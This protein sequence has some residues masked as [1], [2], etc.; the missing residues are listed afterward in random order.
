[1]LGPIAEFVKRHRHEVGKHAL[2]VGSGMLL[3]P[4]GKTPQ[5]IIEDTARRETGTEPPRVLEHGDRATTDA[6][7]A[8]QPDHEERCRL[9]SEALEDSRTSEGHIRLARMIKDGYF[10]IIFWASPDNLIEQA[11]EH[12]RLEPERDFNLLRVGL[13]AP[14]QIR[15]AI[16]EST[17][18]TVVKIGGDL[19]RGLLPLTQDEFSKALA[20]VATYFRDALRSLLV[21]AAYADRDSVMLHLAPTDGDRMYWVNRIVPV[22]NRERYDELRVE[23]PAAAKFHAYQPD[24][25]ALLQRR[26][27]PRNLICR[28][29]GTFDEF[30]G[31]LHHRLQRR[32][33][34]RTDGRKDLTVLPGGPYRYLDHFDTRHADLFYGRDAETE[35]LRRLTSENP[36]TILCGPDGIGKSSLLRAGVAASMVADEKEADERPKWIPVVVRCTGDPVEDTRVAVEAALNDRGWLGSEG[37][38]AEYFTDAMV[39]AVDAA[40]TGIAVY[41]DGFEHCIV[42]RG[43][44]TRRGFGR[45]MAECAER[46]GEKWRLCIAVREEFL[47]YLL[48]L[49]EFWP[50]I[51]A[52]VLR[53][54]RLNDSEAI[55]AILKP[56]PAFLCY[57]EIEAAERAVADLDDGGVLPAHLQ[58]VM[59]RLYEHRS[60]G[61]SSITLKMYEF[62]HGAEEM[63]SE[64]VEFPL[65]KLGQRDRR[66]AR[67]IMKRLVGSQRTTVP[68]TL[69][70]IA[71]ECALEREVV[72][73]VLA[74]LTDLRLVRGIGKEADRRY[75]LIHPYIAEEMGADL[76]ERLV[77][78]A[79]YGD[80]IARATDE[81]VHTRVLPPL[82]LLRRLRECR[83]DVCL[84][85][86]EMEAVLR[87]A[88]TEDVDLDYWLRRTTDIGPER[89]PILRRLLHDPDEQVRR[90]AADGLSQTAD[91]DALSTLVDG[92]HDRDDTVRERATHTLESHDRELV[93]SL[94][95]DEPAKRQRAAHALGIIGTERHVGPLVGALRDD[96]AELTDQATRA[97]SQVGSGRAENVLL[98]RIVGES[99]APWSVA[100]A[101][102]HLATDAKTLDALES[103]R[104]KA[105][106]SSLAKVNYAIGR[107]RLTRGELDEAEQAL[108]ASLADVRDPGGRDAIETALRELGEVR[109]RSSAE[110]PIDW[111]MRGGGANR[112]GFR[113]RQLELPLARRWAFRTEEAVVAS[114]AVVNGMAYVGSRDGRLYCVDAGSGTLNWE[115]ATRDRVES[116]PAVA[117]GVVVFGSMDGTLYCADAASGDRQWT[118][119]VGSPIRAGTCVADG[120]A[121]AA[122]RDGSLVA[123]ALAKGQEL[124]RSRAEAEIYAAP[125]VEGE[126]LV[127]GAWDRMLRCLDAGSGELVW[128]RD[129]GGEISS[130]PAIVAGRA[131]CPSDSGKLFALDMA[132]GD[133]AWEYAGLQPPVRCSPA[134]TDAAVI[135][136]DSA[137][138]VLALNVDDGSVLWNVTHDEEIGGSPAVAGD[139]AFVGSV[140]GSLR[141]LDVNTGEERWK[142]KTAYG[143]Y[144]SPAVAGELVIVGMG[145]Y[146]LWGFAHEAETSPPGSDT[147]W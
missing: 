40:E 14:E 145:Y 90:A 86:P 64:C 44:A 16:E 70:R 116:S 53:L 74:R 110:E 4:S 77:S 141:A 101:L 83:G 29:A 61:G 45:V 11:L 124:W 38:S 19:E 98:Q 80:A 118:R 65:S 13:D 132:T 128:S 37:L 52:S 139:L 105:R 95:T 147:K 41:V 89:I 9:V 20:P 127:I 54:G 143:V 97:L 140:D 21:V 67:T 28:E 146:D 7:A 79:K 47:G 48:D 99:D 68:K 8:Q 33:S 49:Q 59:N 2:L 125:A 17:R 111:P 5:E 135:L 136:G 100:Y 12:Q 81:W 25:M 26:G 15:L 58:I 57:P 144:S 35:E 129:L 134:V 93:D 117:D 84:G 88:A 69:D 27:S 112:R 63:L 75:E 131:Y 31:K 103:A 73:R 113:R 92:L 106:A 1:M 133:I 104:R 123:V 87:A 30:F 34:R 36:A 43:P 120:V 39:E 109:A 114:P 108:Q 138:S 3:S 142:E 22:E 46:L 51:F 10:S 62:L 85:E 55:D 102:G 32:K 91:E 107:A 130:T 6:W 82:R 56:G 119:S 78:A 66:A 42:R 60:V 122:T 72:E 96:D 71:E 137:G 76:S 23:T 94:K 24:V 115:F 121:Y 126:R 50:D 18:I